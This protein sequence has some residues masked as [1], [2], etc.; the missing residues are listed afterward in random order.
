LKIVNVYEPGKVILFGEHFVVHGSKAV[1]FAIDKFVKVSVTKSDFLSVEISFPG[2]PVIKDKVIR[3]PPEHVSSNVFLNY[4]VNLTRKFNIG[5]VRINVEVGFPVAA[6]LGSSAS[7]AAA[8]TKALYTYKYGI[9]PS[10][11]V[12]YEIANQLEVEIHGNPSGIDLNTILERGIVLYDGLEKRIVNKLDSG[13][14]T[15]IVSDTIDRRSTGKL[16]KSVS[17]IKNEMSDLFNMLVSIADKI[18]SYGFEL[19][20]KNDVEKIGRL[21]SINHG[22]LSAIGV[23]TTKLDYLAHRAIELGAYGAKLTGAGGGGC[24][25][26]LCESQ[27]AKEILQTFNSLGYPSFIVKPY[28]GDEK[29]EYE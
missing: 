18:S 28:Y 11:E 1:A 25:I 9:V 15:F 4:I 3:H 2:D 23:S 14:F 21:M 16:V 7:I 17:L 26:C 29:I 22:L 20:V 27:K 13:D 5:N 6:G 8:V 24:L 12:I 19:L 10:K